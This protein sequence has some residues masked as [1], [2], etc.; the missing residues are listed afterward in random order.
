MKTK[1]DHSHLQV[2]VASEG[3]EPANTLTSWLLVSKTVRKLIPVV[4][5]SQA[6]A[7][8]WLPGQTTYSTTTIYVLWICLFLPFHIN[9]IIGYMCF[10]DRLPSLKHRDSRFIHI[11]AG[12]SMPSLLMAEQYSWYRCTSWWTLGLSHFGAIMNNDAIN[13]HV[14][15]FI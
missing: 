11:V 2:R 1:D 14:Q 12:V 5:A 8:L 13:I 7:L 6:V 9:R 10:C 4:E 3:A 15:V